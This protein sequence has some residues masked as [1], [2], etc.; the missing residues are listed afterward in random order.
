MSF[1]DKLKGVHVTKLR[2]YLFNRKF[3]GPVTGSDWGQAL[4]HKVER[5][6]ASPGSFLLN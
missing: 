5:K 3:L 2:F 6:T 1:I 4:C